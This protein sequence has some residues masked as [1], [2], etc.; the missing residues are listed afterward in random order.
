MTVNT[1][2]G[3]NRIRIVVSKDPHTI[4]EAFSASLNDSPGVKKKKK[5]AHA[6]G[7]KLSWLGNFH[8]S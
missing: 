5:K 4:P 3:E 2:C 1:A 8:V 7:C 6:S